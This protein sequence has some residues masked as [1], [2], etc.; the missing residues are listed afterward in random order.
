M[1]D[2]SGNVKADL[3][4]TVKN[5]KIIFLFVNLDAFLWIRKCLKYVKLFRGYFKINY[6]ELKMSKKAKLN[7]IYLKIKIHLFFLI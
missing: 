6:F 2:F 4:K 7:N 1:I 3:F 5:F